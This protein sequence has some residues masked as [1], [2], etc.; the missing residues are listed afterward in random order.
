MIKKELLIGFSRKYF[1]ETFPDTISRISLEWERNKEQIQK[2]YRSIFEQLFRQCLNMQ[3][4]GKKGKIKY[5]NIFYLHSSL[6]T[7]TYELQIEL[8]DHNFYKDRQSCYRNW[9]P[10]FL[11]KYLK[12]DLLRFQ[13]KAEKEIIQFDYSDFCKVRKR[14]YAMFLVIIGEFF[15]REIE[16]VTLLASYQNMEKD[17]DIQIIYGGYLDEGILIWPKGEDV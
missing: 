10:E 14:Y 12:E 16:S 13:K 9:T 1:Q 4:E 11:I 15:R 2:E 5:L 7:E 8:F 3:R 17:T 6:N